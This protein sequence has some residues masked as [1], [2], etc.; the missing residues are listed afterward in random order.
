M[1]KLITIFLIVVSTITVNAQCQAGFGYQTDQNTWT[2]SLNGYASVNDSN[3]YPINYMWS[4]SDGTSYTGQ[5]IT[6]QFT[7]PGNHSVCLTINTANGCSS[8]Y[9]DSVVILGNNPANACMANFYFVMDSVNTV[10]STYQFVD[11][12]NAD[13]TS[14][15]VGYSWSFG[16]GSS[17]SL[18]NPVHTFTSSGNYY[19]CLNITTASG[20]TSSTCQ[21]VYVN[22]GNQTSSCQAG[23]VAY[24]DSMSV[25]ALTVY[26]FY[27]QSVPDSTSTITSWLWNFGN[28]NSS[29]LH[30]PQASFAG[31]G[32]YTV[33]LTISTSS[34]CSN[35]SCQTIIVNNSGCQIYA[36]LA[37][38]SPTTIGGNDGYIE[39]TVY[40]GTAPFSY[41]W[42]TGATT[43]NVYGLTS[44]SY[45]L[46]VVD[47]NGC[48]ATISSY[49]YEPYDT[50]GGQII[51]T[52]TTGIVD[53]CFN[54][55]V[56]SFYVSNVVV[57]PN[58]NVVTMTWVFL[59]GGASTSL[60]VTYSYILNGNT[61]VLI[62]L[63]CGT[64][65]LATY[66]SYVHITST[67]G[68]V[69]VYGLENDVVAYPVPFNDKLTLDYYSNGNTIIRMFDAT[70]RQVI[71]MQTNDMG[72]SS[73]E[74]N[75][76]D[77]PN[78]IYIL[79]VESNGTVL[80]KQVVK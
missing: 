79:S 66:M 32:T 67:S 1:K 13:S 25:P 75:T 65:A 20:C 70:G 51:D 10:S 40:G 27:D 44:G 58:G 29:T 38:Q 42:S 6:H 3:A 17:S 77:L 53:T 41:N 45:V 69:P 2:S 46:N 68:I 80:H 49:L 18:Q 15:I 71:K 72:N 52:L 57:D 7:Y 14:T 59:G 19:V 8:T 56:D 26:N 23:F 48:Q 43:A 5:Y 63:N 21:Y 36:T 9:C 50:T 33:C 55:V 74:L 16:D 30:N 64:K 28:G 31:P 34:G 24:I 61:A 62:T 37:T 11:Y 54:F 76:S 60:T 39:S 78:G 4:F 47:A 12:S 22:N 35:T 73:T